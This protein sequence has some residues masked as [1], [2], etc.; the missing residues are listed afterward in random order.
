MENIRYSE[1][2]RNAY[3]NQSV[4]KKIYI[5][6]LLAVIFSFAGWVAETIIFL[7]LR[8][9]FVDRGLLTLPLCPMYGISMALMYLIL[10]TPQS[11]LWHRFYS[12]PKTKT[13]RLFAIIAVLLIYATLAALLATLAEYVTGAFF[14]KRFGVR[15]W[16]YSH[17]DNN[18]GGYVCLRYTLMWGALAVLSMGFVWHPMMNVLAKANTYALGA[19]A[20]TLLVLTAGDFIFNLLYLFIRGERFLPLSRLLR[21][22]PRFLLSPIWLCFPLSLPRTLL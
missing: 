15:L 1:S 7:I 12:A 18:I 21:F 16:S 10:R 5:Q 3:E 8:E 11:G 2:T 13:G 9:G 20:I 19:I 6:I 14:H 17:K 4:A 22:Y